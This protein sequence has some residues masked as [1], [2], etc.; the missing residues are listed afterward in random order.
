MTTL[1]SCGNIF[2]FASFL[3]YLMEVKRL[4]C[5]MLGAF[6]V[7]VSK[8]MDKSIGLQKVL[9]STYHIRL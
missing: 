9:G 6:T 1:F 5:A 3:L 2:K 4:K 8:L 7:T